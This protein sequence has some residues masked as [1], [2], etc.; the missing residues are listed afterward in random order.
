LLQTVEKIGGTSMMDYPAVR[1]N[2]VV[3]NAKAADLYQRIFVVSAYGGITDLLLENKRNGQP[4]VYGF[5]ASTD[6]DAPW[7]DAFAVLR[8]RLFSIND[9][10]FGASELGLLANE[11]ISQRLDDAERCL[12]DLQRLCQHGHF[13]LTAHLYTVREMLASIG[14]AHSAWNMAHLLRSEGINARF[15]DLTGWQAPH[16]EK[17]DDMILQQFAPVDLAKEL[18][19]ATGYTHCCEGLMAS[20]D[21]GYSEMTFSR[22]A[23]LTQAKEAIIHKEYHLSSA[24]PRLVGEQNAVPIGRTN[25]DVA[26]QLANLGMEAIH[27][28]AAKG[29]RQAEIPLRIKN[30]FE[31]EHRGT[32][33]TGDYVSEAPRV[34]IIAGRKNLYSIEL[35][36]QDMMGNIDRFDSGILAILARFKAYV[37]S[38]D[39]NA[40]TITHYIAANLK[41]VKRIR[42]ALAEQYPGAEIN[43]R[44][45]AVVSAIGSD[46]TVPGML[47]K[48][49]S[50]LADANISI[51]A[52]H[53]S[54]RQVDMQFV[55]AEDDYDLA[56][57]RLHRCLIEVHNHGVAICAA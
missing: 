25:Y 31:P 46:M 22:I 18:P 16:A 27:P 39:M 30:T 26:D 7:Q 11:F 4:G 21:R 38:K 50:A 37:V 20:F 3:K 13:E 56:V 14:E 33:I 36:D 48:A 35:F 44:K 47:A 49:V 15:V 41:T 29:L 2:I 9:E 43:A 45:V 54:I 17:L 34:E 52:M 19:I 57:Q 32:L 12:N 23:V 53:Q 40:N 6:N 24:D 55:I 8:R 28:R 5:F 51:L 1:D 42:E 10:L